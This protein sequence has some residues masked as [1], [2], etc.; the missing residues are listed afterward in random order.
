MRERAI[1]RRGE[2]VDVDDLILMGLGCVVCGF[3]DIFGCKSVE[4]EHSVHGQV[5]ISIPE[6][7]CEISF[8]N[9]RQD[10]VDWCREFSNATGIEYD[11]LAAK[12][13]EVD[14]WTWN[15]NV[16]RAP[17]WMED[18]RDVPLDEAIEMDGMEWLKD[19]TL[20]TKSKLIGGQD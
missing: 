10:V 1:E 11:W 2:T 9:R 3:A 5:A 13:F 18:H 17:I 20:G 8:D 12:M 14:G 7:N 4:F 16:F 19:I 15:K 6:K